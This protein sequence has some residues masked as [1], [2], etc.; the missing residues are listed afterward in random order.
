M[1]AENRFICR[2]LEM[3]LL[4]VDADS[5]KLLYGFYRFNGKQRLTTTAVAGISGIIE[6]NLSSARFFISDPRFFYG[7][8]E[9]FATNQPTP[10]LSSLHDYSDKVTPTKHYYLAPLFSLQLT[11]PQQKI[12]DHAHQ[13]IYEKFPS[14]ISHFIRVPLSTD[15]PDSRLRAHRLF[16]RFPQQV[17]ESSQHKGAVYQYVPESKTIQDFASIYATLPEKCLQRSLQSLDI[18]P[19]LAYPQAINFTTQSSTSA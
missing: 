4:P 8:A 3:L 19:S 17:W 5:S 9:D 1:S 14:Y 16:L 2:N 15:N 10:S 13:S 11:E 12:I 7:T 18:F 6:L